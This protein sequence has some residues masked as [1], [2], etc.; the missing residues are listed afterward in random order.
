MTRAKEAALKAY[1]YFTSKNIDAIVLAREFFRRGYE[2]AET[3]SI[4]RTKRW[5]KEIHRICDITDEHGYRIELRDLIASFEKS[6]E[7]E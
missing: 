6:V 5:I 7:E 3:D 2:Q 1:P 4:L